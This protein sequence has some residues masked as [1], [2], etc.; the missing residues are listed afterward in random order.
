MEIQR[1]VKK[2]LI[3]IGFKWLT[4]CCHLAPETTANYERKW[5]EVVL[6]LTL[7]AKETKCDIDINTGSENN[8]Q[9]VMGVRIVRVNCFPIAWNLNVFMSGLIAYAVCRLITCRGLRGI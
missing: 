9:N 6:V 4:G 1:K 7:K 2:A 5:P 3:V 8:A